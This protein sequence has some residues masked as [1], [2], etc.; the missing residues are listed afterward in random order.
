V[1]FENVASRSQLVKDRNKDRSRS[2]SPFR[3]FR[4]KKS[5]QK[6]PLSAVSAS[7]DEA[8]IEPTSDQSATEADGEILEG[9]LNRKHEWESTTKK[10][11][12]RSWDK[13]FVCVVGTNLAF[14]KDAKAAKTSPDT[15]FKGEAPIDLRGGSA[16]VATDYTKKKFVLRVKLAS[17]AEFLFQA[18]ND[19]EMHQWVNT[20]KAVCEQDA[21]GTQS[22]S[23]TLPAVGDKRGDEPKRRSF[24]TL[25]KV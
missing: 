15:Y 12:N 21:A 22:R 3:S 19:A 23:Q 18:R 5:P 8:T 20:L 9:I 16:E 17:G 24:F 6:S 10:A 25:K 1:Y 11:S 14:Y 2:K 7:D 4:W 13:V